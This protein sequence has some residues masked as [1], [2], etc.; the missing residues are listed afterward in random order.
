MPVTK[1]DE[2]SLTKRMTFTFSRIIISMIILVLMVALVVYQTSTVVY[3]TADMSIYGNFVKVSVDLGHSA[4]TERGLSA[5]LIG[6]GDSRALLDTQRE[7]TD[8]YVAELKGLL[9][10]KEAMS[11]V[12]RYYD[13][14]VADVEGLN[15][16]R[17]AVDGLSVSGVENLDFYAGFIGE[18]FNRMIAVHSVHGDITALGYSYYHYALLQEYIGLQRG[19]LGLI[20]AQGYFDEDLR[21][22]VL[23]YHAAEEVSRKALM[24]S[25]HNATVAFEMYYN[26]T[27][28]ALAIE[29]SDEVTDYILRSSN[30]TFDYDPL[31]LFGNMTVL[32]KEMMVLCEMLQVELQQNTTAQV[33]RS[34]T[35][36][37]AYSITMTLEIIS[38]IWFIYITF[39]VIEAYGSIHNW[40]CFQESIS[41][42]S[43][44]KTISQHRA[45]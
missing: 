39:P 23:G 21:Y 31:T 2:H 29:M 20:A 16:H 19:T 37:S 18:Q 15:V 5:I 45:R 10:K 14:F 1:I 25:Y 11:V 40:C 12:G 24:S 30:F 7:M 3:N 8:Q 27:A 33:F 6:G 34:V 42:R 41:S 38:I 9:L 26:N 32:I 44:S 17:E 35:V 22:R 43:R 13:D 28:V 36:F 4:A